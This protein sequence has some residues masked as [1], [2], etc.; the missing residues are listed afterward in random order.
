MR[1]LT[2]LVVIL[3]ALYGGYWFVGSRAIENGAR[4]GLV[5]LQ[6]DGWDVRYSDLSTAGF[7]SRFDTT[8]TELSLRSP[9]GLTGWDGPFVQIFA[10]SYQPNKV[11]AVLP[12]DFTLTIEGDTFTVVNDRLRASGAVK[13]SSDLALSDITAEAD[14]LA[15]SSARLGQITLNRGLAALRA[16][17]DMPN[18][19][20]TYLE[21]NDLARETPLLVRDRLPDR[22]ERFVFDGAMTFDRPLDRHGFDG[23]GPEPALREVDLRNMALDVADMSLTASGQLT[24][25]A[26]GVPDGRITFRTAQWRQ[27]IDYLVVAGVIDTG[28]QRTVTNVAQAMAAGGGELALPLSFQNG[29]MSIGPLP[30]GPAPR[31]R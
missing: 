3:A 28:M 25:D 8:V 30:V 10:L 24:V 21:L 26:L 2:F 13:A 19:Y 11:I 16:V 23:T 4:Q 14:Q 20:D 17:R 12:R 18:R 1:K 22:L 31:L 9:D 27:L 7:P 29:F 15:V 5:D 6:A